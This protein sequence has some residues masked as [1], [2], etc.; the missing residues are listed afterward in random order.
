MAMIGKTIKGISYILR[1]NHTVNGQCQVEVK[2]GYSLL[3]TYCVTL[4]GK[5]MHDEGYNIALESVA[6]EFEE[7]RLGNSLEE[8]NRSRQLFGLEVVTEE[9]IFHGMNEERARGIR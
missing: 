1:T 8:Y 2:K 7:Y 4:D 6:R 5:D 3:R 9:T